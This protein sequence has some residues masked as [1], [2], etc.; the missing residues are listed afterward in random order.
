MLRCVAL[1]TQDS[2]RHQACRHL[3]FTTEKLLASSVEGCTKARSA[4]EIQP[5]AEV[6]PHEVVA[7][8]PMSQPAL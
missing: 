2:H 6:V 3:N 7:I 1:P 4:A 5:T 8:Y